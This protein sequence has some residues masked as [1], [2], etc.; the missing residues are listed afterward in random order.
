M[1]ICA[2]PLILSFVA[3]AAAQCPG[4]HIFG[5]RKTTVPLGY[6]TA[7]FTVNLTLG[8]VSGSTAKAINYP[9]CGGQASCGS[10]TYASSVVQGVAAVASQVNAFNTKCPST[11]L[12]L[13]GYSQASSFFC[14]SFPWLCSD[15]DS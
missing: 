2:V 7:G 6:G 9:A 10:V 8:A 15:P 1:I 11:Q 5:A 12:V 14:L 3:L 13:I 4:V